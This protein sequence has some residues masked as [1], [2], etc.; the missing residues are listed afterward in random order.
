MCICFAL[1]SFDSYNEFSGLAVY[2][3][4]Y[5]HTYTIPHRILSHKINL[6]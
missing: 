4:T 5:L 6:H 3:G 1:N 2:D